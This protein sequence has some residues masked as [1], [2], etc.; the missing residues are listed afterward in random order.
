MDVCET[1]APAS[2]NALALLKY[3]NHASTAAIGIH[4]VVPPLRAASLAVA[5]AMVGFEDNFLRPYNFIEP[6]VDYGGDVAPAVPDRE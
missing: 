5:S 2:A 4:A 1:V 3:I 6:G